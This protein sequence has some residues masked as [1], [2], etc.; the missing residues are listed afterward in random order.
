MATKWNMG[1]QMLLLCKMLI[2]EKLGTGYNS[3]ESVLFHS[4]FKFKTISKLNEKI[5]LPI[6]VTS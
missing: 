1:S 4:F 6:L 2:L 3:T 5:S